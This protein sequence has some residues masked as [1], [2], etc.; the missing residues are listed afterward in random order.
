MEDFSTKLVVVINAF[1]STFSKCNTIIAF[2]S[3]VTLPKPSPLVRDLGRCT[4]TL[5]TQ[6]S[7][8]L[9]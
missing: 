4:W 6:R 9:I 2:I 1:F 3:Y 8:A 5:V 7:M